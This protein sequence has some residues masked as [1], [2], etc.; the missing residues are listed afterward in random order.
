MVLEYKLTKDGNYRVKAFRQN[1][2]EG[3]IYG[4]VIKT[5]AGIIYSRD[6]NTFSELLKPRDKNKTE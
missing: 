3:L 1:Q 5:G 4:V 2:Y 6:Y